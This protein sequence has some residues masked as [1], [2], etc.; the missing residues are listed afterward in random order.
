MLKTQFIFKT[1]SCNRIDTGDLPRFDLVNPSTIQ[2]TEASEGESDATIDTGLVRVEG[3]LI[4]AIC[5]QLTK[6]SV[7]FHLDLQKR[8]WWWSARQ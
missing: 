3:I 8:E 6:E 5:R 1:E 2:V 4:K 7:L